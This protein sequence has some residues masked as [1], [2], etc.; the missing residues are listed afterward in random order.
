MRRRCLRPDGGH[1][2]SSYRARRASGFARARFVAS[3]TGAL[4]LG[5]ASLPA[6]NFLVRP[7]PRTQQSPEPA[8]LGRRE[9]ASSAGQRHR[10][11][12]GTTS[13]SDVCVGEKETTLLSTRPAFFAALMTSTSRSVADGPLRETTQIAPSLL[14][15]GSRSAK[16]ASSAG[17]NAPP[18]EKSGPLRGAGERAA[19]LFTE[20]RKR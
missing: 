10:R 20:L 16:R 18:T 17:G 13:L 8:P 9:A 2:S 14:I 7:R 11:D 4:P 3:H 5:L 1:A 6:L 12:L 15:S 19:P